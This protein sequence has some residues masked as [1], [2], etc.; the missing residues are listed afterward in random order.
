MS[1]LKE[2]DIEDHPY[3]KWL[4][5]KVEDAERELDKLKHFEDLYIKNIQR[6]ERERLE[7]KQK[8]QQTLE[9]YINAYPLNNKVDAEVRK[10]LHKMWEELLKEEKEVLSRTL[11]KECGCYSPDKLKEKKLNHE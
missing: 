1:G 10:V 4:E 3:V 8:L 9:S 11:M 7:L 5:K 2:K 6:L